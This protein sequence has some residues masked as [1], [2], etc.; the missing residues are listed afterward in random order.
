MIRFFTTLLLTVLCST[1]ADPPV[2]MLFLGNSITLH[3]PAPD[4]GWTGNWGMAATAEDKDF[5]HL[6]AADMARSTGTK[7]EIMVRNIADFERG[8]TA[9]DPA[10]A[11]EKELN[12]HASIVILAIGENVP[13]PAT[14]KAQAA[15]AAAARLL[16]ETVKQQG[17]SEVYV[18]SSFWPHTVKDRLLREASA[19]AGVTFVD[20]SALGAVPENAARSE[21]KIE[22]AGVAGHPGDR[23]MKALADALFAAI[24]K[25]ASK[26]P[27]PPPPAAK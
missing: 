14:E 20:V 7:P 16:M 25:K 3:A 27:A 12:F 9:Y 18:R 11:L 23:G 15:F 8:Y 22:H 19:A 13:E 21:R 2:K 17:K 10:T 5:V 24:Q 26:A 1:A 4:I 6:L